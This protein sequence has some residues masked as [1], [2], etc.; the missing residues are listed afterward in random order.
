MKLELRPYQAAAVDS[1]FDF[2]NN[3]ATGNP[4]VVLPTAT[5]KSLVIAEFIERAIKMFPDTRIIVATHVKELVQQNY[6]EF[7][8][9]NHWA[10]AGIYSAG[11]GRREK[12]A[13]ILFCGIQSVYNKAFTIGAADLL[14]VDECHVIPPSGEGMWRT[15]IINLLICNPQMRCIGLSATPYR[16]S[17]GMVTEGENRIF[18]DICYEYPLL[19]AVKE[20]YVCE[21]VPKPVETKYDLSNVQKR[22]GEFVAGSLEKVYNVDE[23]T[24]AAVNEILAFGIDR[25]AWLVFAAGSDHARA[26]YAL[27][28]ERGIKCAI[29]LDKTPK[30]ERDQA[31][32]DINSG[33]IQCLINN[34]VFTTGFNCKRIDL[35]VSFR[36]T[37][38]PG[39]WVQIAGRGFRLH[40]D[41][42]NCLL[43]DFGNN[44]GRHGP[45]D[46][47][48]GSRKKKGSGNGDAPVKT[49]PKCNCLCFAA[50]RDCPDCNYAF[51]PPGTKHTGSASTEAVLST[52]IEPVWHDVISTRYVKHLKTGG[53]IPVMKVVYNTLMGPYYDFICFEH[54]GYAREK[55]AKW[56]KE[57]STEPLPRFVDDALKIQYASPERVQL[58][59]DGK[60]W[61]VTKVEFAT[62]KAEAPEVEYYDI[63]F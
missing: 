43:L 63:P 41:K 2:F 50:A 16:M 28:T 36:A 59:K 51:P 7:K 1:I 33:A 21:L 25:K 62:A 34:L 40:P 15:F 22:G 17:S 18:T 60:Y 11:V 56:H 14:I 42:E 48:S 24:I 30:G 61:R 9:L 45:L 12:N 29:V 10:P 8:N 23:K 19:D 3:N 31:V 35:L 54:T 58:T 49:C 32:A 20:G 39:L 6:Q 57:R 4:C 46:K 5:G 38:S 47:I 55:A 27:L 53:T 26:L 13:Q 37:Q 52:Q 44:L